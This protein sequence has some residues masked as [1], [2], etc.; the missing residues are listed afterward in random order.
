[1]K[2]YLRTHYWLYRLALAYQLPAEV[3]VAMFLQIE[4]PTFSKN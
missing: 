2:E 3:I 4:K 1:M